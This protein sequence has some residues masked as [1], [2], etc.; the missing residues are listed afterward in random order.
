MWV[1][2]NNFGRWTG[3]SITTM[4]ADDAIVC[5]DGLAHEPKFTVTT[6]LHR[7]LAAAAAE[8][9]AAP[10]QLGKG[11]AASGPG[12][13]TATAYV[14]GAVAFVECGSAGPQGQSGAG[15]L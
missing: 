4:Y 5:P 7:A 6:R 3:D 12:G 2:G 14:Y 9:A 15:P 1:G 11:V 8:V 10:A 13:A